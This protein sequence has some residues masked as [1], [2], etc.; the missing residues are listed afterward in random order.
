MFFRAAQQYD[1]IKIVACNDLADK[2]TLAHLFKYDSVHGRF[3]G[4]VHVTDKGISINGNE[5]IIYSEKDPRLLPWEY[6]GVDVVVESTGI[7]RTK[8]LAEQHIVAG[9]KKVLLSAPAKD[10]T[11]KTFVVGVNEH[12]YN[13]AKDHVISNASCTTNCLAPIVKVLDD[14]F[15]VK[16]GYMT[17][18]HAYTAD[19]RLQDA[20]HKDMRRAR[21][22]AHNII[23]TSTGA[24]KAVGN[25]I[26][27]LQGKLDGIALRV[28]VINGSITDFVVELD[29]DVSVEEVNELMKDV[30]HHHLK[31]VL[32]YTEEPL[33]SSDIINN[34][35]SSIFD[36]S[37]TFTQGNLVKVVSWYDNEWGYSNRLCDLILRMF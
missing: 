34:P 19:Q 8:M 12:D 6:L 26:P 17:T 14:N 25:V 28:P 20:P 29:K 2:E 18:T 5:I 3:P 15:G 1:S 21:A 27:H 30:S 33:V 24:A 32:Y 4:D 16:R 35:H 31:D 11:I 37:L 13:P 10:D 9:A 36:A 23:P 22:A 7:F